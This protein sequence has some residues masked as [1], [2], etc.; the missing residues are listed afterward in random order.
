[1][2]EYLFR[3]PIFPIICDI[4]G[5]LVSGK[6]DVMFQLRMEQINLKPDR[7]YEVVD[8]T[9]A[10][11][12]FN[13]N[14]SYIIPTMSRKKS[15][16]AIV[17]SYNSSVNCKTIGVKYSKKSLSSKRFEKIYLDIIELL[18]KSQ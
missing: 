15:K 5:L 3:L 1:M 18:E 10:N 4:D 17:T 9:G 7:N 2:I 12:V 6:E 16:M 13:T 14:E 8:A 11:W